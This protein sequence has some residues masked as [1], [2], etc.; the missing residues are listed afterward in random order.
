M[1]DEVADG[2]GGGGG[3]SGDGGVGGGGG[4][5]SGGGGGAQVA[6]P[7]CCDADA[8][9]SEARTGDGGAEGAAVA[10]GAPSSSAAPPVAENRPSYVRH[11]VR[12]AALFRVAH[13]SRA[14]GEPL[15]GARARGGGGAVGLG[16]LGRAPR[17]VPADVARALRA[18]FAALVRAGGANVR[19][20][21][22][23][24]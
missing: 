24:A 22:A 9:E 6:G 15:Q 3:C 18:E 2:G 20:L 16:F 13:G 10:A 12:A 5:G 19:R 8:T 11:V 1:A 7:G 17:D 4:G 14:E 21:F 23:R